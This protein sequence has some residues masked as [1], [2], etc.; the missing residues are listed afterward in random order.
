MHKAMLS[1]PR[2]AGALLALLAI[3]LLPAFRRR[4][5]RGHE[6]CRIQAQERA[7]RDLVTVFEHTTDYVVQT[8]ARGRIHYMNP[9]L[10]RSLGIAPHDTVQGFDVTRF[11]TPETNDLFVGTILP[12]AEADGVWI[13][14]TTVYA[15]DRR[16]VPVNQ[17]V[18]AHKG[19]DGRVHL[20]SSVMRDIT[21]Q[22]AS[23]RRQQ[24]ENAR[25]LQ[26]SR[27][28]PLTGL[29]NRA[30]FEAFLEQH[31]STEALALLYIDL[32]RFKAVNDTHGHAVG[33]Q[34]L[35]QFARRLQAILRQDDAAARLGGD[36][37]AIALT[38]AD[39]GTRAQAMADEVVA[40]ARLQ[41]EVA[42]RRLEIG[43]SVGIALG[44]DG[45]VGWHTLIDRADRMLYQAK[46][47]GRGR[48]AG[49]AQ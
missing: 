33:D 30:G 11:N 47:A 13:G 10:R 36:E 29:L 15:A 5:G 8:D 48:H 3:G 12:A 49:I 40:A 19:A 43:A 18:I 2:V 38:G 44:A 35:Q 46:K 17:M 34:L 25:L 27:R 37:F 14:E 6:T 1:A 22:L 45:T 32:D 9:A 26:L 4:A 20:Y 28:D 24:Q 21:D 7:W 42:D 16:V 39:G 23:R 41:F 31:R